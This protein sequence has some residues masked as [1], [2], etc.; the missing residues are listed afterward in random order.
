M[1]VTERMAA[2]QA[3]AQGAPGIAARWTSSAKSGVGTALSPACRIWFTISH[4]ILNEVYYP[5][6]DHACTRDLGLIVCGP[7][8]Y[9]SEE[10]RHAEHAVAL[11]ADGVPAYR[12]TNT[13]SDGAYRIEKRILVDPERPTVLQEITFTALKGATGDYRVYALLAPHLVNAGAGN[14]AWIGDYKGEQML[15]AT[16]TGGVSLALASSLP[17]AASSAGYVGFSD[18][19]QQLSKAGRL[20]PDCRRADNGNVA[21]TGEIGFSA[22]QTTALLALAFGPSPQEAAYNARASLMAGF[23]A[24]ANR[25]CRRLARLAAGPA[26]ARSQGRAGAESLPHQHGGS[27]HASPAWLSGP[28]RRKPVDPMGFQQGRRGS[29]RLSSGL[30]ARPG[31]DGRRLP[32]R[33]CCR[34]RAADPRLSPH[35]PGGRRPLAAERLAGRHGL[36]G[37]HP[38]G[39]VRLSDTA[40][41][42]ASS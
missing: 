37:R 14:T 31:R 36:L 17:W 1:P 6:V 42:R 23:D 20:D 27:R 26:S 12:L 8:G 3:V 2:A 28:G 25:L 19:W 7:A 30:A 5:R 33:G 38:D 32:G 39:R 10:K 4:G 18:G 29:W 35:D 15:F 24:A 34:R 21:L 13:A 40:G 16:G 22:N 11:F 9:F 41:G